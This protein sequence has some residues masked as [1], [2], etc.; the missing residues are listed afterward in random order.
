MGNNSQD[1]AR[2]ICET[3]S[4]LT[5]TDLDEIPPLR[6]NYRKLVREIEWGQFVLVNF[7]L[8]VDYASAS[9]TTLGDK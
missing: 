9:N 4:M 7:G 5:T 3:K 1:L 2:L 6:T 8:R